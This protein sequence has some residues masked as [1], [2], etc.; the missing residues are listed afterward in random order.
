M[1]L[2][3]KRDQKRQICASEREETTIALP[4][5]LERERSLQIKSIIVLL[6]QRKYK[7]AVLHALMSHMN[8]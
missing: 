6:L 7:I 3:P 5:K 4:K 1:V 8:L 2:C